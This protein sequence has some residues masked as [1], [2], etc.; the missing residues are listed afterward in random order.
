MTGHMR[1]AELLF[2][3]IRRARIIS[4]RSLPQLRRLT[5][6]SLA[7]KRLLLSNMS[8][9]LEAEQGKHSGCYQIKAD[10]GSSA[11]PAPEIIWAYAANGKTTYGK[12]SERCS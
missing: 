4:F 7:T 6:L 2:P 1:S 8:F 3:Y 12:G 5:N 10:F 9:G 11:M